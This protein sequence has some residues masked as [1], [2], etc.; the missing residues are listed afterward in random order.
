M[1]AVGVQRECPGWCVLVH[2]KSSGNNKVARTRSSDARKPRKARRFES[3][4]RSRGA[5]REEVGGARVGRGVVIVCS[6]QQTTVAEIPVRH[7]SGDLARGLDPLEGL[8]G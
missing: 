2:R 6:I 1:S 8:P 4:T 5:V 7:R 3:E